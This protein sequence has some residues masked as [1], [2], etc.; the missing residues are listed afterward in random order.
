MRGVPQTFGCHQVLIVPLILSKQPHFQI[1]AMPASS[2]SVI[3][4]QQRAA[5]RRGDQ[6]KMATC[7]R[8]RAMLRL[9]V[10][11]AVLGHVSLVDRS[12][13][14][15]CNDSGFCKRN[16]N[17][18][19]GESP[20]N[21]QLSTVK[22]TSPS[23]VEADV[24]NSNTGVVLRLELIALEEGILR[25]RLNEKESAVARFEP[26][27][28]LLE[29]IQE[30][31][32]HLESKD[33]SSFA[34]TFGKHRAVVRATP[35]VV[36]VYSNG[37]LV[38]VANARGL[39]RF[40]HYR[41]RGAPNDAGE[42]AGD[43]QNEES[44]PDDEEYVDDSEKYYE[45]DDDEGEQSAIPR[46][47][48]P[49]DD[50]PDDLLDNLPVSDTVRSDKKQEQLD[51]HA[52]E[53]FDEHADQNTE[54]H[55]NNQISKSASKQPE[56]A[57]DN[58]GLEE[59]E[60]EDKPK[61]DGDMEGA[62]EETF[63]GHTDSKKH[64]PMSVGLDFTFEGFDHVYGLP[65]HADS[66]ALR[67]TVGSSDPVRMYNLDVF[68]YEVGNVMALYGSV[69]LMLAHSESRTVGV[70]WLNAAETWVDIEPN[71]KQ[72]NGHD[73]GVLSSV[74]DFVKRSP[75]PNHRETHWFSENGLIDTFFLLGP[76]P[77]DVMRQYRSLTGTTPLPPMFSVAYHQSR[78]N[79]N[80]QDDVRS[81]DAGFDEHNIPYDALWLDIE[82]TDGKKYFTWDPFKFS[83]PEQMIRN[84]TAKGRRMITIIDPHIKRESGYHI[85]SEATERG[86]YV[87]NKD[88]GDFEGWCWPG[89][90]SYLDF[91]NPEVRQWW[92]SKFAL[93]QY[94]GSTE[95]LFTWNDMNEPSV[96]NGPEVTMHKDCVHTG[97]WE[98]RDIHNMY[99]MFLPMS[100]YMG[101][102]LRS[103]HKLRPFILSR[104]FFIG[105]QRYGA[106]WTGDNDAD[107]K[108][109][110][111]TVPM[112]LSLS[113]A[114]ISFCGADVGGFFRNP[115]SELSVRWYQAGA[116]QPFFR[117]HSH[118]H[119]KRREPW[120]FGPETLELVRGALYQRYA[121]LPLWYTL[122]FENERTGVPPLRPLW[123]E[124]PQDKAGFAIDD[125][126][127][128]G[129]ALLVHPVTEAGA[130]KVSVYF[131]GENEVWYDVETWEKF[132]G[133]ST[134]S[135]PVTLSK[136]P[137]Y[138]RGGTIIPKKERIRR[139][140]TLTKD[141]PYTL[142]VALPKEGKPAEGTLY[143]DDGATFDYKKGD[144]LFLE[145]RF[146]DNMLTS[147]ILEGPGNFKTKAWVERVVIAGYPT[148]P[149][150]VQLTTS[151][152]TQSLQ[153]TYE[154][155]EQLLRVRKPGVNVAEKWT[156]KILS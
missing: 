41:P 63:K 12:N 80:D 91:L 147:K 59:A 40:E 1:V 20:Y 124:F 85:H 58:M 155:K 90:S 72:E 66:F 55:V 47:P 69:P 132:D 60:K 14:K 116:Y 6:I 84:L 102:L 70:L 18:K 81:V 109:L 19:P 79:Y 30:S 121:L 143:I 32:F 4:Q 44:E 105:S 54:N 150:D 96:F 144:L 82:H 27:E 53:P 21:V 31:D 57:A 120:S 25:M 118:I 104:S 46:I 92:A 33:D 22:S 24:I 34:V 100:T 50:P 62:W 114:G 11:F 107:W 83:Q 153:F 61:D 99:G 88:G 13:F 119:T 8:A 38:L 87:K 9:V 142:Q 76:G 149:S 98:H 130:T 86:Y 148:R 156:L 145:F 16:R 134:V 74:V 152:G 48:G 42:A 95:H 103:G 23:R 123:M 3:H 112:L 35:L 111:I 39:L 139:C 37:Q 10:L 146:A 15:S 151:K 77:K 5:G 138:Q 117:A 2:T 154:E 73:M 106:V 65:E 51:E 113:V 68:E 127:L 89:S 75:P 93:D 7:D 135:I 26:K 28:A 128:V 129:N 56:D 101:H 17:M 94:R 52:K 110:R 140:S 133:L 67:S 108:H 49:R 136:I 141:D 125:E 43:S 126:H 36:E 45:Y 131:P 78:W 137:V 71:S 122:F 115:D 64:G 97:G 29:S